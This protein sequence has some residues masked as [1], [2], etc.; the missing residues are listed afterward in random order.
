LTHVTRPANAT[1][2]AA[3]SA[4]AMT[5]AAPAPETRSDSG[6]PSSAGGD[7]QPHQQQLSEGQHSQEAQAQAQAAQG[8]AVPV[9]VQQQVQAAHQAGTEPSQRLVQYYRVTVTGLSQANGF[10]FSIYARS[11][12]TI[13]NAGIHGSRTAGRRTGFRL[14][15]RVSAERATFF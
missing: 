15:S 1:A 3:S 11:T 6:E 5:D 14:P 9:P 10:N 13:I 12:S 8:D 4:G 7:Q 2:N